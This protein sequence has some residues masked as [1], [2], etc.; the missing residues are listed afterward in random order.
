MQPSN[1]HISKILWLWIPLCAFVIQVLGENIFRKYTDW[2]VAENGPYETLQFL[3]LLVALAIAVYTLVFMDKA[4]K[5]LTAWIG[6]AAFCCFYVAGEEISWGQHIVDWATPE[7]WSVV[8][9]QNETNLHNTSSWL[10]QKPRALLSIGVYVGGLIIP[11]LL[12]RKSSFLPP[13]LNIIYPTRQ[14]MLIA[15]IC[16]FIKIADKLAETIDYYL[17][18]RSA[19]SEEQFLFYFVFL[20][21]LLMKQRLV[22]AKQEA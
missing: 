12:A 2:V 14:F 17:F 18:A 6:L 21:L 13:S 1:D 16:L 15:G 19:E 11:F 22:P 8:N 5:M 4:N 9:D 3:I 20:Y 10:D 7:Y